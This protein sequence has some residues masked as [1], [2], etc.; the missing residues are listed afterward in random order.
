M[1]L[2]GHPP[3]NQRCCRPSGGTSSC[4][5]L[6]LGRHFLPTLPGWVVSQ[7]PTAPRGTRLI[8]R[9]L[10]KSIFGQRVSLSRAWCAEAENPAQNTSPHHQHQMQRNHRKGTFTSK[11]SPFFHSPGTERGRLPALRCAANVRAACGLS[12]KWETCS[13]WRVIPSFIGGTPKR[14]GCRAA[15]GR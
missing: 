2:S 10:C 15:G 5:R 12:D 9:P 1:H 6:L 14:N 8:H 7:G 11:L 13:G 3:T 4:P